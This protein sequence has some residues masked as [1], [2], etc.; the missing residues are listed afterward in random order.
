MSL[1]PVK[2][3]PW[4]SDSWTVHSW[5]AN[6]PA[7]FGVSMSGLQD[8]PRN[9]R[10]C[11]K[12]YYWLFVSFPWFFY[13]TF[14]NLTE[15]VMKILIPHKSQ[16]G[17]SNCA[18]VRLAVRGASSRIAWEPLDLPG[19]SRHGIWHSRL[20]H[21]LNWTAVWVRTCLARPVTVFRTFTSPVSIY[22][23]IT[24]FLSL[25]MLGFSCVYVSPPLSLA[26][27]L[28]A[29]PSIPDITIVCELFLN[30]N[31][32]TLIILCQR[33]KL[34]FSAFFSP[35]PLFIMLPSL[36]SFNNPVLLFPAS[37]MMWAHYSR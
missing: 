18:G 12:K 21:T 7:V 31:N 22:P 24:T 3:W 13:S 4:V 2:K 14:M 29:C 6:P 28:C 35:S 23:G 36:L 33:E 25:F 19:S 37:L 30:M 10:N 27:N 32:F 11:H 26:S 9:T 1:N 8:L 20:S 16:K 5:G 15:S 34:L 17:S